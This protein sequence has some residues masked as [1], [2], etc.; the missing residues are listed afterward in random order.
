MATV[1]F[2]TNIPSRVELVEITTTDPQHNLEADQAV[3]PTTEPLTIRAGQVYDFDPPAHLGDTPDITY[4]VFGCNFIADPTGT[5]THAIQVDP[6]AQRIVF[7]K[8]NVRS[9]TAPAIIVPPSGVQYTCCYLW[10]SKGD[11]TRFPD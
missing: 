3:I 2:T 1:T 10:V 6:T 5:T 8:D 4:S 9:T 11:P 7:E